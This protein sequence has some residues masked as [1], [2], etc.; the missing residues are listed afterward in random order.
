[1]TEMVAPH[2]TGPLGVDMLAGNDGTLNPCIELNLR[3][4]MGFVA[5]DVFNRLHEE[6][7]LVMNAGER[8]LH[9]CRRHGAFCIGISRASV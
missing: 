5:R 6:G 1:M 2:D 9:L 4:T 7:R 3:R 8:D